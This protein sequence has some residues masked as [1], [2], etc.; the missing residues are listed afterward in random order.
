MPVAVEGSKGRAKLF[1][2][3]DRAGAH[4]IQ[5]GSGDS[6]STSSDGDEE[7]VPLS[8]AGETKVAQGIVQVDVIAA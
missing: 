7:N 8:A 3:L 1:Q 6:S 2:T 5:V 4:F